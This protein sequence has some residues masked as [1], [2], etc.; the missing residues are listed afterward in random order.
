MKRLHTL[1]SVLASMAAAGFSGC[2]S[3]KV[4]QIDDKTYDL[5]CKTS[6]DACQSKAWELCGGDFET[7][8]EDF[9]E[10]TTETWQA[11]PAGNGTMKV[12]QT[13]VDNHIRIRCVDKK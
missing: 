11:N 7:V 5:S 3:V 4:K 10:T 13:E 6:T 1:L 12:K 8:G 9:K 2:A